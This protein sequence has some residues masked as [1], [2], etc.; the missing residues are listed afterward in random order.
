MCQSRWAKTFQKKG[1]LLACEKPWFQYPANYISQE[2][3]QHFTDPVSS[4][5][6]SDNLIPAVCQFP[7]LSFSEETILCILKESGLKVVGSHSKELKITV[8]QRH[9]YIPPITL[10]LDSRASPSFLGGNLNACFFPVVIESQH[11]ERRGEL[12]SEHPTLAGL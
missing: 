8:Q 9:N 11:K 5:K 2:A 7:Q 4:Y 6:S 10:T 12:K 1:T 3:P